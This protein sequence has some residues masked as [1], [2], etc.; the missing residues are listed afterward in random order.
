[1]ADGLEVFQKA[2]PKEEMISHKA[3]NNS[4]TA[5]LDILATFMGEVGNR[6]WL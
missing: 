2:I 4:Y 6:I 5:I 3:Q 1:M